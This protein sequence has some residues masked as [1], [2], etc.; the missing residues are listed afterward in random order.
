ML[1]KTKLQD[2][3][4][5]WGKWVSVPSKAFDEKCYRKMLGISYREHKTNKN[6]WQQVDMLAGCQALLLSTVASYHGS[7]MSVI[8]ICCRRLYDKEQWICSCR[9]GRPRKSWKDN[10]KKW[11]GQSMSSLLC[12]T[13]DDR[14]DGQSSQQMHLSE[15]PNDARASWVLVSSLMA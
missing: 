13:D 3:T 5:K 4:S 12:I 1:D 2:V 9:R 6:V 14:G 8:M 11:T 7:A 15:Y 10:V